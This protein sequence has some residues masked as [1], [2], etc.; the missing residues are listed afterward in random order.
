[1]QP[2]PPGVPQ[3]TLLTVPLPTTVPL[4]LMRVCCCVRLGPGPAA[5]LI[6]VMLCMSGSLKTLM[7]LSLQHTNSRTSPV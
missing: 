1:M 4:S 6:V 3:P 5:H 2:G 7:V